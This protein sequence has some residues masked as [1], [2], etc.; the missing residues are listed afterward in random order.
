MNDF[1]IFTTTAEN[2]DLRDFPI[3]L[4]A[5]RLDSM[6]CGT[7]RFRGGDGVGRISCVHHALS[8]P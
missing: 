2:M 3:L 4:D 5:V 7:M 6:D 8:M 1:R